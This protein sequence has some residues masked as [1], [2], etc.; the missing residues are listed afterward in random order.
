MTLHLSLIKIFTA[1]HHSFN[2]H[3]DRLSHFQTAFNTLLLEAKNALQVDLIELQQCVLNREIVKFIHGRTF[4]SKQCY[5]TSN[6]EFLLHH[7]FTE[8]LRIKIHHL[9]CLH[10]KSGLVS[11]LDNK[12]F[13]SNFSHFHSVSGTISIPNNCLKLGK[14]NH[15]QCRKYFEQGPKYKFQCREN[16]V[17]A[18]G[19]ISFQDPKLNTH[20]LN[21]VPQEIRDEYFPIKIEEQRYFKTFFC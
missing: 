21:F 6:A 8:F 17:F 13:I 4:V 1:L 9:S 15:E 7:N 14:L 5:L 18:T 10:D 3:F 19:E 16:S 11:K 20:K 2:F 12:M